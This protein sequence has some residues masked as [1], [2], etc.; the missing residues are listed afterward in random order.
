[1]F[2]MLPNLLRLAAALAV[3]FLG[4]LAGLVVLD[5]I[6]REQLTTLGVKVVLLLGIFCLVSLAVAVLVRSGE[7]PR[8]P[9]DPSA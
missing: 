7:N 2:R 1:M 5:I 9:S 4:L 6:P 3:A 8:R